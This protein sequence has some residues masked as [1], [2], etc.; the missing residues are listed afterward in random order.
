MDFA[1]AVGVFGALCIVIAWVP[2]TLQT[3]RTKKTGLSLG[4]NIIYI[5][6]SAALTWYSITLGDMV[7][8]VLNCIATALSLINLPFTIMEHVGNKKGA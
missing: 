4:F 2:E 7:F 8:I 1:T 3:L 5:I 6:G